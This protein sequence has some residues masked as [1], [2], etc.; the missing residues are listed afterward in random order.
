MKPSEFLFKVGATAWLLAVGI[1]VLIVV[2]T[3][4][5]V[6]HGEVFPWRPFWAFFGGGGL[7]AMIAGG[8]CLIWE[9]QQ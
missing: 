7:V 9:R 6:A 8:V 3:W 2:L 4:L 5:Q 1:S